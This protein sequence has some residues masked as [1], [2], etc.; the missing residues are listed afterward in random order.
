MS[1]SFVPMKD[2]LISV[3]Q[4]KYIIP[5]TGSMRVPGK[6]FLSKKLLANIKDVSIQQVRNVANLPGIVG[7]SIGMPD[8]HMGYGFCV[9]GVSAF[10]LDGGIVSPGGIGFDINCGVRVLSSNLLLS[11][12]DKLIDSLLELLFTN[13]PCGVG[14][15]SSNPLSD[16]MLNDVLSRGALWALDKGYATEHDI[17]RTEERGV[18]SGA[19]PKFVSARARARGKAQLGTLGAGNHFLELQVVDKI[20]DARVAEAF[21]FLKEGQVVVM[22]HCGSRGLGHQVCTDYLKLIEQEFPDIMNS[23][24]EKNLAYAPLS[25]RLAHDYLGAM[26]AAANF[27]FCNRQIIAHKARISFRRLFPSARLTQVYDVAHNIAKQEQ[28]VVDGKKIDVL[29]HRKGATR[30]FPKGHE[31]ICDELR[32]Y[33]QPVL[34]PGSMGTASYVLVG[35]PKAME[36]TFGSSAHGAGRVMSRTQAKRDF[37]GLAVSNNL[38]SRNILVRAASI[39]GIAE[40]APEVYKDVDEVI[41]VTAKAGI[42]MPVVRLVPIG[43]IKG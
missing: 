4:T 12:V 31:A 34:I 5:K 38:K 14:R 19:K 33:G 32:P 13:I 11:D 37:N 8:M 43:V 24:Q 40:E 30:A 26:R 21:G 17:I 36:E 15:K 42:A 28:H 18:F 7:Y 3:S 2:D 25:S 35:T 27:A 1:N 29:V 20:F 23:L 41:S 16:D 6:L 9:G 39:K 22:I 10:R